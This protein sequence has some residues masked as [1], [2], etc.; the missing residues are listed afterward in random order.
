VR[1][2]VEGNGF[3]DNGGV[4][5]VAAVP[6]VVAEHHNGFCARTIV[7]GTEVPPERRWCTEEAEERP[8]H[9]GTE[10]ALRVG[11]TV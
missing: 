3:P 11:C 8:C 9:R 10:K 4:T 7:V 2:A 6:Q 5:V 1:T